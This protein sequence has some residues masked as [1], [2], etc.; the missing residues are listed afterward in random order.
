[1]LV[2]MCDICGEKINVDDYIQIE[3]GFIRKIEN[4]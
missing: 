3:G 4:N 1:M 2:K